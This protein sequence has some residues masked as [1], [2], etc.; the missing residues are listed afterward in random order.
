[1]KQKDAYFNDLVLKWLEEVK[2]SRALSTYSKYM[3]LSKNYI[4]PYFDGIKTVDITNVL[5]VEF[6]SYVNSQK[7]A[8]LSDG[9]L[10]CIV[11]ILNTILKCAFQQGLSASALSVSLNIKKEK[12]IAKVFSKSEQKILE[13]AL[14][15][16]MN[17]SKLGIYMCLYTGLR[18]GELCSLRW[19]DIDL[20]GTFIFVKHTIQR[21]PLYEQSDGHKTKLVLSKPKSLSSIRH[22]PITS[23]ILPLLKNEKEYSKPEHFLLTGNP[24]PMEPRTLQYQY[25]NYLKDAGVSYYNFHTLRHTF[26]TRCIMC[27]ID[28]KTLSEILGHSD[29]KITLDYYF[30][31]SLEFKKKQMELLCAV[32]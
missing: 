10:R 23:N 9:N 16:N 20:E 14:C 1:M 31:S 19:Q 22:V 26:A 2:E 7:G 24:S 32:S 28:P 6:R 17:L 8:H 27:G 12:H 29:I 30:H 21:I 5:L 15:Q 4:L 25:K 13:K 3:Q 11:M 18:L